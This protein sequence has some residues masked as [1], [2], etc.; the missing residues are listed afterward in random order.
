LPATK[1]TSPT[2]DLSPDEFALEVGKSVKT[3]YKAVNDGSIP[4]YKV[5]GS[6][7]IPRSYL[8][9]LRAS[10]FNDYEATIQRVVDAAPRLTAA[11]R[12]KLAVLL[13]GTP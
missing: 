8:D 6:R 1:T 13:Q 10:A 7:R 12:D 11:Q 5:G 4:S 3:V 9:E 2:G